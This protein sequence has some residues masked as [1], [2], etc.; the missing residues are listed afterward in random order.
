[1]DTGRILGILSALVVFDTTSRNSNLE[2][3][4]WRPCDQIG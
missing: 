2:L 4:K 1:M 3:M